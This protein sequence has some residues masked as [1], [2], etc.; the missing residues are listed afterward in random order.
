MRP[1][2]SLKRRLQMRVSRAC[3]SS[4]LPQTFLLLLLV[5]AEEVLDLVPQTLLVV[6]LVLLRSAVASVLFLVDV[7]LSTSLVVG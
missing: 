4:P 5:E 6:L 7:S 3:P 2:A 1:V